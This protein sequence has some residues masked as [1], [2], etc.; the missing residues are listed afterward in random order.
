M[1]TDNTPPNTPNTRRGRK[2]Q[3]EGPPSRK[4]NTRP[5]T[6]TGRTSQLSQAPTINSGDIFIPLRE[7][8]HEGFTLITCEIAKYVGKTYDN[9]SN[10]KQSIEAMGEN[11]H[12]MSSRTSCCTPEIPEVQ[13][14]LNTVPP[15][16]YQVETPAVPAPTLTEE[17]IW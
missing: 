15:I 12:P 5:T 11:H 2:P 4:E 7:L 13:E 10:R 6:Q 16:A 9:R 8:Q 17:K 3:D 14:N 1:N